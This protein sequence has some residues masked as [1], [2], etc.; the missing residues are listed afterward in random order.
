MENGKLYHS[1]AYYPELWPQEQ[2]DKD[3]KLMKKAGLNAV[4]ITE[5]A[6]S[7]MEPEEGKYD[8]D[9]LR[10]VLDK[11]QKAKIGAILCTPTPTPP[12]WLTEKHPDMLFV[13]REGKTMIHGARRHYCY[14]SAIYQHLCRRIIQQLASRFGKHPAV[15]GWQTD[16]EFFCHVAACYCPTCKIKFQK[17]LEKKYETIDNLNQAWGTHI[18][19][20]FEK[21][22]GFP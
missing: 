7:R 2:I 17:R 11:L 22:N 13:N 8:F 5:F 19:S 10:L 1:A 3:L 21:I 18:W 6:W 4:R 14:N 20:E 16:N 15:I 9:W 12:A